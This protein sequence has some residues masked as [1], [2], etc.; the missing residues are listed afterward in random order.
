M[1]P[2]ANIW[3]KW[4][5]ECVYSRMPRVMA[6]L[7]SASTT[8][9]ASTERTK[10]HWL[11]FNN[12]M[13]ATPQSTPASREFHLSSFF[14]RDLKQQCPPL[15]VKLLTSMNSGMRNLSKDTFVR[16]VRAY[17]TFR[18]LKSNRMTRVSCRPISMQTPYLS[19][20]SAVLTV[21]MRQPSACLQ[22]SDL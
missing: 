22:L 11:C 1:L 8:L 12:G 18:F 14:L 6:V 13:L 9:A 21:F 4:K 19:A 7:S 10:Y 5:L 17:L 16:S 20:L 2:R 3:Q 15:R